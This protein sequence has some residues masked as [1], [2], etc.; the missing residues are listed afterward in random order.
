[1]REDL[2]SHQFAQV[3]TR[4]HSALIVA[5]G[6]SLIALSV[7]VVTLFASK[8]RDLSPGPSTFPPAET[9][10]PRAEAWQI[11]PLMRD[12]GELEEFLQEQDRLRGHD[13]PQ[14]REI[15][16]MIEK[17]KRL[18][19]ELERLREDNRSYRQYREPCRY[20]IVVGCRFATEAQ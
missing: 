18:L 9:I 10:P 19:Q 14:R 13:W 3:P 7:A 8:G 12:L 20:K 6:V 5:L 11:E 15:L 17:T 2:S 1:M 16:R 4:W